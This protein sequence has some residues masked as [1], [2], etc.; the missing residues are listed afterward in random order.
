MAIKSGVNSK[1]YHRWQTL[2]SCKWL[3][4]CWRCGLIALKNLAT[5]KA[6]NAGCF[7]EED[8]VIDV[9]ERHI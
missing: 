7:K 3:T 6:I 9:T 5:Q 2:S 4:F 8:T 1:I